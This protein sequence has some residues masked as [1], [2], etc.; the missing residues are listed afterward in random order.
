MS[1]NISHHVRISARAKHVYLR[2]SIQ[3]GLQIVVPRGYDLRKVPAL[4]KKKKSWIETAHRRLAK[5]HRNRPSETAEGLPVQISLSALGEI[6]L[7]QYVEQSSIGIT[8]RQRGDNLLVLTGNIQSELLCKRALR[9]WLVQRGQDALVPWLR[10]TSHEL[11]LP[12]GR[13]SVRMQKSRWGS[14]SRHKTI[15]LNAK[16][17]FLRPEL[18]CYL[19]LHELCHLAHMNHSTAYWRLV[20]SKESNY[21]T[22]DREMRHGMRIVP[23]WVFK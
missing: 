3:D 15:S 8:L 4:L 21:K 22:L 7:V 17:L 12:F 23:S 5:A 16:L 9:R 6:W 11:G 14:C 20:A 19:F 13:A 18:V 2:L 10:H 1:D